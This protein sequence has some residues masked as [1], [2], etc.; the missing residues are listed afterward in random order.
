VFKGKNVEYPRFRKEWW[1][2]RRNYHGHV[3]DKLVCRALKE[4]SLACSARAMVSAIEELQEVWD[5]LDTCYEV[6]P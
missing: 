3:C 4:K 5:T 1:A 6:L 2:W